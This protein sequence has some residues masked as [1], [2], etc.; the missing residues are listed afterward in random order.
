MKLNRSYAWSQPK[1]I[2]IIFISIVSWLFM[3]M[4]EQVYALTVTVNT[5]NDVVVADGV[6]S[7]REAINSVNAAGAGPH[8][9]NFNGAGA[10]TINLTSVLP[11]IENNVSIDA[12]GAGGTTID[13]G[14]ANRAFF[15]LSGTVTI[16][17]L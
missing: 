2:L 15:V 14:N 17:N 11:Q 9:I 7:L 12:S 13:G 4:P 10:G 5:T 1:R 6:T 16:K 8:T 3:F